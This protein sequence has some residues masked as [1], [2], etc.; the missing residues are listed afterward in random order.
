MTTADA[1]RRFENRA[2]WLIVQAWVFL[3]LVLVLLGAGAAAVW[4]APSITAG[5]IGAPTTDQKLAALAKEEDQIDARL[6][7]LGAGPQADCRKALGPVLSK[8]TRPTENYSTAFAVE[9]VGAPTAALIV[10]SLEE[11]AKEIP[12][13]S[14]SS[15]ARIVI[16]IPF[17]H[18]APVIYIWQDTLNDFK[19]QLEAQLEGKTL[20]PQPAIDAINE[21]PA[22][23]KRREII[24]GI[25][26]QVNLEKTELE[27]GFQ[28]HSEPSAKGE[29]DL[30]PRLLQTSVT[31]FGLL[32]V[33]GFFVSILASLYRYNV[34]I[35]AFYTARAD[36][37]RMFAPDIT[38]FDFAMLSVALSPAIEFGKS[39]QPPLGQ[40]IELVKSSKDIAK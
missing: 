17:C 23:L 32:A 22:L 20:L 8:W 37:L 16:N 7:E 40:L 38:A 6:K 14:A 10:S 36:V 5:D 11:R 26:G 25:R 24:S 30:F 27:L 2:F 34:R 21:E 33:V 3:F 9:V 19:A 13:S 15:P 39:S 28:R 12:L 31:R 4:F 1:I 29:N 18:F 35:A